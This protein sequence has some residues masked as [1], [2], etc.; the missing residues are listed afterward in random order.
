LLN[1]KLGEKINTEEMKPM[2]EKLLGEEVN[3][4]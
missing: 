2:V 4:A 3:L 1:S